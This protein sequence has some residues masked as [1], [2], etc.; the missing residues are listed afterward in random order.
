MRV[1]AA[2]YREDDLPPALLTKFADVHLK[3]MRAF[4][5]KERN[6]LSTRLPDIAIG[7]GRSEGSTH[8]R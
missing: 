7:G 2:D 3:T 5:R 1:S 6:E 8:A 4:A